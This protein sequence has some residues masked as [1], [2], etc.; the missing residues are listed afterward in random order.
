MIIAVDV[1]ESALIDELRDNPRVCNGSLQQERNGNG[2]IHHGHQ[3]VHSVV[4][5]RILRPRAALTQRKQ[6]A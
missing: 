5:A 6:R 2:G 1:R 4:Y 3:P